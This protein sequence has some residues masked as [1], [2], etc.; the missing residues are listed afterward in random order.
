MNTKIILTIAAIS[1]ISGCSITSKF[2]NYEDLTKDER[3]L[4][5]KENNI[6]EENISLIE[7]NIKNK[8][9]DVP[10]KKEL[11]KE[12]VKITPANKDKKIELH[13]VKPKQD[14][15]VKNKSTEK[16]INKK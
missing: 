2:Q 8:E 7:L 3:N 1:M 6:S 14:F 4:V 9:K 11:K 13:S 16:Q 12:M 15:V 5:Y 10:K